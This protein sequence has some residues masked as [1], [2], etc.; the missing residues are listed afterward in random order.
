MILN[1]RA[2]LTGLLAAPI[3]VRP[4]LL[5][6]VRPL[7]PIEGVLGTFN[8]IEFIDDRVVRDNWQD[9]FHDML[10]TGTGIHR[11]SVDDLKVLVKGDQK[12]P[13][14]VNWTEIFKADT[15]RWWTFPKVPT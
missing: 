8:G 9:A 4:G 6:P 7:D 12:N 13:A 1:R 14:G 5:M 15:T 11:V 10:L 3:I 2:F